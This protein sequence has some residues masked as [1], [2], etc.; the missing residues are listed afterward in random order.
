MQI[1]GE[2]LAKIDEVKEF[3]NYLKTLLIFILATEVGLISW[4]INN[5]NK[6]SVL[7]Y[8]S[9]IVIIILSFIVI[10][11]NKKIISDIK[12]LKDL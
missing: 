11:I 4:I 1:K 9:I 8:L 6:K 10:F 2:C 12:K 3:I 5:F 7:T